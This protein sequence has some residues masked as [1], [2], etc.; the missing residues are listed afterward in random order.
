MQA[1][2][3]ILKSYAGTQWIIHPKSHAGTAG[4]LTVKS[5]AGLHIIIMSTH[6]HSG[7]FQD[8]MASLDRK[9]TVM[10]M[11][12]WFGSPFW[13]NI[14]D[15]T[16]DP[17][18]WGLESLDSDSSRTRIPILLDSDSSPKQWRSEGPAGPRPREGGPRGWRGPPGRSSRRNP[19]ARGPN[20]LFA[21]G[22]EN[23]RYATGPKLL[24]SDSN[25]TRDMRTRTW[26]G[27][28]PGLGPDSANSQLRWRFD[29]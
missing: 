5:N 22:P 28:R 16:W 27:L 26:L 7:V 2:W 11:G 3:I 6:S 8:G 10:D 15:Q 13:G 24:D 17:Q 25:S 23:R 9:K 12:K 14:S 29:L 1:H 21:G 4:V 19:L 18:R 20:K